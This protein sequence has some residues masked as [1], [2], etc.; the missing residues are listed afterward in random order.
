MEQ[1]FF[2]NTER[3]VA[4]KIK[5]R[6]VTKVEFA[7]AKLPG[8]TEVRAKVHKSCADGRDVM[9]IRRD[10]KDCQQADY[11]EV[12][13]NVVTYTTAQLNGIDHVIAGTLT[14]EQC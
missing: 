12:L 4:F 11:N 1:S 7:T 10:Y 14:V 2:I 13:L 6:E 9:R 5:G 3:T 8:C